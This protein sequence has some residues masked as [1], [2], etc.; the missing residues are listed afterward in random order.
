MIMHESYICASVSFKVDCLEIMNKY[1]T[2]MIRNH[3]KLKDP[4]EFC[5]HR[6]LQ[7]LDGYFSGVIGQIQIVC[8]SQTRQPEVLF[9]KAE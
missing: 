3:L 1:G 2:I 8:L 9:H 4:T 5:G 7:Y 6:E